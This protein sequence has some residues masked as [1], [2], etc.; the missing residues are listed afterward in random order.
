MELNRFEEGP[1]WT[2]SMG[3]S[4]SWEKVVALIK[5]ERQHRGRAALSQLWEGDANP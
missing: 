3:A 2:N 4:N 5:S 1:P